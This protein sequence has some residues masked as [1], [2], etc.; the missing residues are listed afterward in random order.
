MSGAR[1]DR[2]HHRRPQS[3]SCT[4]PHPRTPARIRQIRTRRPTDDHIHWVEG[5]PVHGGHISKIRG[6]GEAVREH[7]TRTLLNIRD[8]HCAG[9][10]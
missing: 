9:L 4:W 10:T 7:P 5:I 1:S 6:L 3:G 2:I 8:V